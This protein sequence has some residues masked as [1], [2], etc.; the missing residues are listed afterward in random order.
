MMK[1]IIVFGAT[2][3]IGAYFTDYCKKNL[4]ASEYEVI[5]VGRRN[6]EFF[7]KNGIEYIEVDLRKSEDFEKLPKKNV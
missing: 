5:A 1:K 4:D 2:G 3:S 7:K 6:T